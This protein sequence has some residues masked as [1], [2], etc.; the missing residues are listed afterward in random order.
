MRIDDFDNETLSV[1]F[2]IPKFTDCIKVIWY[3]DVET[4]YCFILL[5]FYLLGCFQA[6]FYQYK[7]LPCAWC[8]T[9]RCVSFHPIVWNPISV[10]AEIIFK[11]MNY[12]Y[13]KNM[14]HIYVND[15]ITIDVNQNNQAYIT[16][17]NL[18]F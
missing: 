18:E 17:I 10:I 8:K 14:I 7:A 5:I 6:R 1:G 2:V 3:C 13:T 9:I 11:I 15:C 12:F 16:R 4:F